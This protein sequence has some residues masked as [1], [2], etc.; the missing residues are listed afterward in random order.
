MKR[1][2]PSTM[3]VIGEKHLKINYSAPVSY[4]KFRE[5]GPWPNFNRA[6]M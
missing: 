4:Q 2:W 5:T 3:P 1:H 6:V